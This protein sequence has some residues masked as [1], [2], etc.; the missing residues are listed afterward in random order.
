MLGLGLVTKTTVYIAV[1]LILAG[2][3]LAAL[4]LPATRVN[5]RKLLKQ[6]TLIYGSAGLMALPWYMRNINLY[7]NWDI[8]GL[9]RHDQVVVGQLRTG[10]FLA[11]VGWWGYFKEFF[12]TTFRS[13][14]GQFGW[15][16]VP[17]SDRVYWVLGLLL[18]LALLGWGRKVVKRRQTI[19]EKAPLT[20]P[21]LSL[22][23]RSASD[24]ALLLMALTVV[25][26]A[27]G[28]GWYNLE[29]TQFQGRYLFPAL[30]PLAIFLTLGWLS[31]FSWPMRWGLATILGLAL[32]GQLLAGLR[33]SDLDKTATL[34]TGLFLLLALGR[35]WLARCW[36]MPLTWLLGAVYV[37]LAL[38]TLVSPFWYI[39]PYLSP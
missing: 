19:K 27:L 32:A 14:W 25:L 30:I 20:T 34:L 11:Q 6:A 29:F 33:S 31:A 8:L 28:Y 35:I 22:W 12:S 4:P 39:I 37:G 26:M 15:M 21:N 3:W 10:E 1:P 36:Q 23:L 13:F 2:L 38:L 24:K 16:A 18:L 17:M 5:W 7:G 9:T